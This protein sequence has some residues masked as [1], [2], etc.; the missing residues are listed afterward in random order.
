MLGLLGPPIRGSTNRCVSVFPL[1]QK[2]EEV[3]IQSH[4]YFH[5]GVGGKS[6]YDFI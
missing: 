1:A 4:A 2:V 5:G 6:K 3:F